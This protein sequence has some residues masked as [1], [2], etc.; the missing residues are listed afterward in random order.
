MPNIFTDMAT[1][2]KLTCDMRAERKE[3]YNVRVEKV[4]R[5][6]VIHT[7][8][9]SWTPESS[10]FYG[11]KWKPVRDVF[12]TFPEETQHALTFAPKDDEWASR[13]ELWE[14][15][16]RKALPPDMYLEAMAIL[17]DWVLRCMKR[18]AA[19]VELDELS[20]GG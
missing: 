2:I 16:L 18:R 20:V 19:K 14:E 9:W 1:A 6:P 12:K 8:Y 11:E 5:I 15:P 17:C 13:V 7:G 4:Y 10:P 3:G